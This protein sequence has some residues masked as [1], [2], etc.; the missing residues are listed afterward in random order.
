VRDRHSDQPDIPSA[1]KE[2]PSVVHAGPV[3][4]PKKSPIQSMTRTLSPCRPH[5]FFRGP[6][7]APGLYG[8]AIAFVPLAVWLGR[9]APEASPIVVPL[10]VA[11]F[12]VQKDEQPEEVIVRSTYEPPLDGGIG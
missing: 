3:N 7:A 11:I 8:V 6:P 1:I 4:E 12:N 2:M 10:I 9:L 5:R